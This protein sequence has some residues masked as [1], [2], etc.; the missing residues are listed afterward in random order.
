MNDWTIPFANFIQ[1]IDWI[2]KHATTASVD[3]IRSTQLQGT[4]STPMVGV[5][6]DDGY[7]ENC[8]YAIPHL[9][10][11]N[12]PVTYFVTTHFI[13]TGDP[14]P[15][16]LARGVP[17]R[18]NT[19]AE[20]RTMAAQGV[21]IG[22]HSHTHVDF[23]RPLSDAHLRLEITDVRK[24][25]QDWTGQ[26]INYFAFPFGLKK[27]FSQRAIDCVFESGFQCFFSAAGG[28]N[29]PGQDAYHLQRIHGD[30]GFAAFK[31]WLTFDPRKI[32]SKSPIEYTKRS[33]STPKSERQLV[34]AH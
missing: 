8:Q 6:F 10:E 1:Q 21:Q 18:P 26:P 19:K 27:N 29:W 9:L 11:R 14:F 20:I 17:L 16:D 34:V 31:N 28:L 22:A 25:L 32:H 30:P 5:T 33:L 12:I 23:G 24:R 13:E 2:K 7:G 15:H 4:R 3:E